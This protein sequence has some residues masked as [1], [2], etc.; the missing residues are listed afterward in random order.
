MLITVT[1][2]NG[3]AAN[4]GISVAADSAHYRRKTN[5]CDDLVV[6]IFL[7][8]DFFTYMWVCMYVNT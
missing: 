7:P 6:V 8:F 4:D 5:G 2:G 3:N 1:E